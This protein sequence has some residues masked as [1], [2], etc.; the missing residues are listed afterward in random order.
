MRVEEVLD[1]LRKMGTAQ[2]VK[3]YR[4]HGAGQNLFGVSFANLK[5]LKRQLKVNHALAEALWRTGNVDA[6]TLATMIADP[7]RLTAT[8]ADAWLKDISYY[9]LA[10]LLGGL[11][12]RSP[13]AL[14][15]FKK[16]SKSKQELTRQ[17]GYAILSMMLRARPEEAPDALCEQALTDI[18]QQIHRSPNRARHAMNQTLI[19]IGIAKPKLRHRAIAA[20]RRIG[21]VEVDHGETSCQTPDAEAYINKAVRRNSPRRAKAGC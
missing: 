19:A 20:A 18:E 1:Q 9:L 11:V 3:I 2:N 5:Q 14:S 8:A 6:M 15:K 10:D 17:A 4:R 7:Q 13:L 16:W 12:A 21:P